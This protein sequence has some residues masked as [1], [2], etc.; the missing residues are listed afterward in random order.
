M[1]DPDQTAPVPRDDGGTPPKSPSRRE[2]NEMATGNQRA[3]APKTTRDGKTI[4]VENLDAS[5]DK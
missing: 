2:R 3:A 4:V 1:D 5:N